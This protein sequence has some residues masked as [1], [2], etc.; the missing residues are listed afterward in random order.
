MTVPGAFDPFLERARAEMGGE[1]P[2]LLPDTQ[3]WPTPRPEMF[4]GIAGRFVDLVA[5]HTEAD[6]VALLLQFL[7]AAGN[8]L[9]RSAYVTVEA[10]PHRHNLF[11][12]I[13]GET[14]AGRKGTALD[15]ALRP[16]Q[17]LDPTWD[18]ESVKSG[19]SSGE[20]LI[21]HARDAEDGPV[22]EK[23]LFVV[24]SEFGSVL[25]VAKREGNTLS[26]QLRL[27]W[28]GRPLRV[29]TKNS[30]LVASA[31]HITVVGHITPEELLREATRTDLAGGL[32]NRFLIVLARRSQLLPDGGRPPDL[33][34]LVEQLARNA[35]Q[36]RT[37]ELRRTPRAGERWREVYQEISGGALPGLLGDI[38]G[39]APAHILRLS[40]LY[41]SLDG[42]TEVDTHH[43]EAALAVVDYVTESVAFL[44][45]DAVGDPLAAKILTALQGGPYTMR[46]LHRRLGGHQKAPGLTIAIQSLRKAGRVTVTTERTAGRPRQ[47]VGLSSV[48]SLNSPPQAVSL[49][50]VG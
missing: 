24:E 17:Q 39:R 50:L 19:L 25:R 7:A 45:G 3:P 46:E 47:M 5:P 27:A 32:L 36:V 28:D 22:S 13:V 29:L 41:A 11:V 31:A 8:F 38:T 30:P 10:T 35:G 4:T 16:I 6:R 49:G 26:P 20:G 23:R 43:L 14:G 12:L 40:G 1:E 44:F 21:W 34:A 48:N 18:Q 2:P 37:G 33:S 9:G 15:Q 42:Q